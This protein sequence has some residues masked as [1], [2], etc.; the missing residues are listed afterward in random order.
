MSIFKEWSLSQKIVGELIQ[1]LR[2]RHD[3][4]WESLDSEEQLDIEDSWNTIINS[5]LAHE[6]L[7]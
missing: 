3:H 7:I 6:G 1:D 4:F 2:D 5:I